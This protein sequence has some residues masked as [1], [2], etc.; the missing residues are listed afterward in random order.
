[1]PLTTQEIAHFETFGYLVRRQVFTPDELAQV[2]R[3]FEARIADELQGESFDGGKR[4][5]ASP[6]IEARPNLWWIP[7]DDRFYGIMEQLLG[8]DFI[9]RGSGANLYVGNTA[10]HRDAA[11]MELGFTRVNWVFNLDPV[12]RGSGCLRLVPGSH[13][14]P[15][16]DR[17]RPL[18]Y[19]RKKQA[20]GEGRI[21]WQD[22]KDFAKEFKISEDDPLFGVD[23]HDVPSVAVESQPGDVVIFN[24]YCYHATFGGRTGRRMF[25]MNFATDPVTDEQI[26]L[27]RRHLKIGLETRKALGRRPSGRIFDEAFIDCGRPRIT[28][29]TRYL[30]KVGIS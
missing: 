26:S 29:M 3:E 22:V 19:G 2:T 17:L 10:W 20:A 7:E 30:E 9:W 6:F 15:F 23:S 4:L 27:L 14:G 12:D 13:H 21:P 11:D 24:M 5:N 8:P 16:H 1:M 28:R 18:N 25:T